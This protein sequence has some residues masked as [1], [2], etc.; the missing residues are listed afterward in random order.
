MYLSFLLIVG[1]GLWLQPRRRAPLVLGAALAASVL[2]FVLSNF[3]VW[4]TDTLYPR[5]FD[6]LVTCYVMAIPFFDYT[7]AGDLFYTTLM[8]GLFAAAEKRLPQAAIQT[9]S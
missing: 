2:F 9:A 3:G 1:L 5:T 6:G 7:V 4:A 8:F